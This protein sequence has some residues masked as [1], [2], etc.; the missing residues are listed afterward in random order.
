MRRNTAWIMVAALLSTSCAGPV[1]QNFGGVGAAPVRTVMVAPAARQDS[2]WPQVEA[3]LHD[4]GIAVADD[5]GAELEFAVGARPASM[6]LAGA[7]Q[8]GAKK[9]R[10]LQSCADTTYRVVMALTD[11][12]SGK[13]LARGWA[14]EAHC[15]ADRAT[16]VPTL[17]QRAVAMMVA[18]VAAGESLRQTRD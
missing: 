17:A 12:A 15:H 14:E 3:A 2:A 11:R 18:P 4:G 5:A 6:A 9:Q 7:A 8:S 10:L 16:V 13:V 1:R